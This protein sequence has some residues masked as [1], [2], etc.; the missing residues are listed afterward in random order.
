MNERKPVRLSDSIT[1]KIILGLLITAF[2]LLLTSAADMTWHSLFLPAIPLAAALL[3]FI[4]ALLKGSRIPRLNP[5]AWCTLAGAGYFLIRAWLSPGQFNKWADT[6]LILS[7]C[8]FYFLGILAGLSKKQ[9]KLLFYTAAFFLL[10]GAVVLFIQQVSGN[11]FTILRPSFTILLEHVRNTGFFGYKNF[12]ANFMMTGGTFCCAYF[13]MRGKGSLAWLLVG[14]ISIFASFWCDSRSVV[15]NSC[16]AAVIFWVLYLIKLRSQNTKFYACFIGGLI[17]V[18]IAGIGL[19]IAIS[20]DLS[21]VKKANVEWFSGN[22]FELFG[23]ALDA[24]KEAPLFGHGSLS[25]EYLATP[26]YTAMALPNMAHNEY[27][28]TLC[29]YG[30]IGLAIL[31]AFMIL[32]LVRGFRQIISSGEPG[33]ANTARIAGALTLLILASLHASMEF[34]WHTPGIVAMGAFCC[35]IIAAGNPT[36]QKAGKLLNNS[37]V[38]LFA[39]TGILFYSFI[40]WTSWPVWKNSWKINSLKNGGS[41]SEAVAILKD[42]LGFCQDPLMAQKYASVMARNAFKGKE[43]PFEELEFAEN[44]LRQSLALSPNEYMSRTYLGIILSLEGKFEEA[45]QIL[46]PF[47]VKGIFYERIFSWRSSYLVH[48]C[49]WADSTF[50][51]EP[52]KALSVVNEA[53][54]LINDKSYRNILKPGEIKNMKNRLET[55]KWLLTEEGITPEDPRQ[56]TPD[57]EG[58]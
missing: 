38:S 44:A 53:L 4:F 16:M 25:F 6:S 29:D 49:F 26:T 55:E 40:A 1:G 8:I 7:G 33:G 31:V 23:I 22:R 51:N 5:L 21:L 12:M 37:G 18:L 36:E 9:D 10:S 28:Q 27:V 14:A 50:A 15:L 42:T 52:G 32:H 45:D 13:I 24:A 34:I 35:G 57:P 58:Q 20:Q 19:V 41:Y 46:K 3:L 2:A 56:P 43:I 11:Y 17:T 48:L 39:L 47:T 54:A 30:S